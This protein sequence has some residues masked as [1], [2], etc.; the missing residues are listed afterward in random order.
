MFESKKNKV[1][2]N[3]LIF[4]CL[5]IGIGALFGGFAMVLEPSGKT[6]GF[7]DLLPY[8]QKLPF[9]DVLFQNFTFSG[10]ALI[11]VNGISN[12]TASFLLLNKNDAIRKKG[13]L[14]GMI[15]GITLMLWIA[16]QFII[17]PL[18][19]MSTIYF[20]FGFL[21]FITGLLCLIRCKQATFIFNINDY[22]NIGSDNSKAVIYFSR[23]GYTR[24]VAY[25]IANKI[26]ADIYEVKTKEKIFGDLGFWWS[27]RFGMHKWPMEIEELNIDFTKYREITIC[28]PIWVFAISA[29]IRMFCKK[30]GEYG[31][32]DNIKWNYCL[33]HYMNVEFIKPTEEMDSLMNIKHNKVLNY[34]CHFGKIKK[35]DKY[36]N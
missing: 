6:F 27:G 15:F 31:N 16:I 36:D 20:I 5:F 23:T 30:V 13:V 28:T 32:N 26:G 21:Q 9:A 24:K 8:F 33:V 18:N 14:L 25:E 7:I 4:W 17:F 1:L 19:F 22:N 11:I 3:I 2:K 12:M 35:V 34:C 10:I 29:P